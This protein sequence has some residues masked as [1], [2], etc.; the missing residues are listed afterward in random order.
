MW[1]LTYRRDRELIGAAIIDAPSIFHARMRA[2]V[3][4]IGKAVNYAEGMELSAELAARI[5]QDCMGRLLAP[6]EARH[7]IERIGA[8]ALEPVMKSMASESTASDTAHSSVTSLNRS[9]PS[10]TGLAL[11]P[12]I[13]DASASRGSAM[14]T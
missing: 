9:A 13:A 14:V 1:W 3:C 5:P 12:A 2:A 10:P 8:S 7:L 11:A 6:E 4:G